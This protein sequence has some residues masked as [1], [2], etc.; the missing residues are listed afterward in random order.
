M[1][2]WRTVTP[3]HA[4]SR[5]GKNRSLTVNYDEKGDKTRTE[6]SM[7][8]TYRFSFNYRIARRDSKIGRALIRKCRKG[9]KYKTFHG[10]HRPHCCTP[11]IY[12]MS[13]KKILP[14][15]DPSIPIQK[16][17]LIG[18]SDSHDLDLDIDCGK[19]WPSCISHWPLY[20]HTKISSLSRTDIESGFIRS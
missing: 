16:N 8:E 1:L 13:L 10:L 19:N 7:A 6:E 18:F 15:T 3:C 12:T 20:Q 9:R 4:T 5:Q 11:L 17:I 2:A 14:H